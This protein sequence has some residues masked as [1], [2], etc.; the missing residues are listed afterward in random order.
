MEKRGHQIIANDEV[1][2]TGIIYELIATGPL[3]EKDPTLSINFVD[4]KE[5]KQGVNLHVRIYTMLGDHAWA[6][7]EE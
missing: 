2:G 5:S 3:S 4:T 7:I 6:Y 1:I